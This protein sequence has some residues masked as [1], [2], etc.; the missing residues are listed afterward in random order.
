MGPVDRFACCLCCAVV[1]A[2]SVSGC[3]G[4]GGDPTAG[5]SDPG[6]AGSSGVLFEEATDRLSVD[7]V[8]DAGRTGRYF[9]P[10]MVPPGAALFDFD[11]DGD[12]D[13]DGDF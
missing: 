11:C 10:E 2:A 3:D 6:T 7:F 9:M 5:G 4:E 13:R 8:H 12:S 1:L